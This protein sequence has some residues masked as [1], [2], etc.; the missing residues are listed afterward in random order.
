MSSNSRH[1]VV[2]VV[3]QAPSRRR[4]PK[5]R[6]PDSGGSTECIDTLDERER[7]REERE[8]FSILM[9]LRDL[10]E[11]G[12]WLQVFLPWLLLCGHQVIVGN[13]SNRQH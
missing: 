8:R 7:E 11:V 12:Q 13:F 3:K 9:H 10:Y 5:F 4:G 1:C 6:G 2:K